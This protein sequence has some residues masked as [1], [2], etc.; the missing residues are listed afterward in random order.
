MSTTPY[1]Q[2]EFT[3]EQN[4]LIGGLAHKMRWVGLFFVVVGV[5]N[6]LMAI[7]LV[8][9]I[10]RNQLPSEW[11]QHVQ[12]LPPDV[13]DKLKELP[14][15]DRLWSMVI[16]SGLSGIIYLLLGVWTRT[17]AKDFQLIVDT[18]GRD[19][20]L[21]M[22]A[23]GAMHSM[24]TLIYT[25]LLVTLFLFLLSLVIGLWASFS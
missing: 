16:G 25:L 8:A 23:L 21:L 6:L 3:P 14:P 1:P 19:I 12:Q 24:Y 9:A 15:Q 10:Y 13:Q 17:A 11:T 22:N 20:S 7:L 18:R 2:Y 4:V 5:V